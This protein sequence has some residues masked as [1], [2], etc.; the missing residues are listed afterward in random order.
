M[1]IRALGVALLLGTYPVLAAENNFEYC[2]V[3]H[4]ANGNG[5]AAI[6]AP[7][8]AGMEPWYLKSQF[9]AFRSGWRGAAAEDAP[10]N[11]MRPVAQALSL[12][13][14]DQAI[15]YVSKFEARSPS[16]TISGD[17]GRGKML[18]G[19]CVAC[20]GAKAEGNEKLHAPA[21]AMRTDWYLV[22]QIMNYRRGLRGAEHA[23]V[24]GQQMR[25]ISIGLP[26]DEAARDV[27][28]YIESLR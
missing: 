8:I 2:T 15:A 7:R 6:R 4:G 9:V 19:R 12:E 14:I 5:N 18:Y 13:Q 27:V 26:D 20:H 10:G 28:S 16:P 3:C 22:A 1:S 24:N 21:L 17:S 23:D 25:S 11:E